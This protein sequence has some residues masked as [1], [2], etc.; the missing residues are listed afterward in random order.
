MSGK[1]DAW[2]I[3]WQASYYGCFSLITTLFLLQAYLLTPWWG[4]EGVTLEV[5]LNQAFVFIV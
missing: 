3:Q 5:L 1:E 2:V 4:E